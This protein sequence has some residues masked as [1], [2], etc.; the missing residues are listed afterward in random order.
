MREPASTTL[1]WLEREN[2]SW[3]SEA[4]SAPTESSASRPPLRTLP[5]RSA[6]AD[7]GLTGRTFSGIRGNRLLGGELEPERG[8][9]FES[10]SALA[11]MVRSQ[12]VRSSRKP[13][14]GSSASSPSASLC[15]TFST[16]QNPAPPTFGC[17]VVSCLTPSLVRVMLRMKSLRV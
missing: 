17:W 9:S 15:K 10:A 11:L 14:A 6:P 3:A 1:A 4:C 16:N 5:C 7:F 8:S 2:C 12:S 13:L